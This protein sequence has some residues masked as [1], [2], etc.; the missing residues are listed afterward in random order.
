MKRIRRSWTRGYW[1]SVF[2]ERLLKVD[3]VSH[4]VAKRRGEQTDNYQHLSISHM[5]MPLKQQECGRFGQL[6]NGISLILL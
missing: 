2:C 6:Y 5:G 4:R 1:K 3:N